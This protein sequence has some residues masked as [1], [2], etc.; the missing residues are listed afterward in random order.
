[1]LKTR[2]IPTLLWKG[3]G[4]V[5]G[6]G[7]NSWRRVGSVLP[8]IKVYDKREVDELAVLDISATVENSEPDTGSIASFSQSLSVPLTF[9]GGIRN[10]GQI[11]EL[12][13][14]GADKV[15]LNTQAVENRGL[16]TEAARYFGTQCV[17][18][19]I[20]A[21]RLEDGSYRCFTRSGTMD[22]GLDPVTLA[23]IAADCGAGEILITS[24]D[25]DGTMQGY[26]LQLVSSV[27]QA[28]DI[29]VIASGGAGNYRHMIDAVIEG[30]ATAVAAASIFHFTEQTPAKAKE[31]M[32]KAG[33]PVR[34]G[35]RTSEPT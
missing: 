10:I 21:R 3:P 6:I 28:V 8:A 16:I 30:G 26:D 20:D 23:R 34:I 19:S 33:I 12:L 24:I 2:V 27:A 14:A 29:P 13:K 1:M 4:L 15:S 31:A 32:A 35:L 11:V 9:G 17:V 22:T 7:F 18:V 25:R 5:K